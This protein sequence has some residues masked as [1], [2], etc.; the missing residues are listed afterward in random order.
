M[1]EARNFF[2]RR[3]E[4]QFVVNLQNHLRFES[5]GGKAAVELDH[6]QL[7]EIGGGALHGRVHGGA[8]GKIAQVGL[9]RI[10]FRHRPD[11]AEDRFGVADLAGFG[12]LL[13]EILFHAAV[14]LKIRGDEFGGFFRVD[15]KILREAERR[16]PVNHAE[17]DDFRHAAMLARLLERQHAENFLRGARVDVL[18]AAKRLDQHW[19]FGK[20]R[21]DAQLDLRIIGGKQLAARR[22]DEG[23]ANFAA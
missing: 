17:I 3:F 22:S 13:V 12:D 10:D 19:I 7:D 6:G 8:F 14:A 21:Q 2:F 20:M 5:L 16:K 4:Q 18:P 1:R 23:G 15:A 11:A 9:R